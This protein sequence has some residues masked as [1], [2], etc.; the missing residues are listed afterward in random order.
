MVGEVGVEANEHT[1]LAGKWKLSVA[2]AGGKK[3]NLQEI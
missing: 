1:I 3:K 2:V